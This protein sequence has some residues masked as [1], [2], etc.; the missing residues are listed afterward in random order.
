MCTNAEKTID[1]LLIAEEPTV[2]ILLTDANL[3]NTPTG[4]VVINEYSAI[5]TALAGWTP[6]TPAQ[7]VIEVINDFQAGLDALP[8]PETFLVLE[9]VIEAGVV[10][11]IGLLTA[12]SPAPQAPPQGGA[13]VDAAFAASYQ[14]LH[15]HAAAA[16]AEAKVTALTGFK[17]SVFDKA[18][19]ALGDTH[20]AAKHYTAVWDKAYASVNPSA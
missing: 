20:V 3:I 6:G 12:N 10:T 17:P 13:G 8:I 7:E 5:L 1:N 9:N 19:A 15:A 11:A 4:T 2:K 14:T 16:D 18:R